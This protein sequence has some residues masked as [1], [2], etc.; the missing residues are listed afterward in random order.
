MQLDAAIEVSQGSVALERAVAPFDRVVGNAA[1]RS[2]AA[3]R[4]SSSLSDGWG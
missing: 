2:L 4:S 1:L 3:S